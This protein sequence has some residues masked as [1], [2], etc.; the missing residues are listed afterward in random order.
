MHEKSFADGFLCEA[1]LLAVHLFE[2][3]LPMWSISSE[4]PSHEVHFKYLERFFR[5]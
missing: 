1:C 2:A 3:W 4:I 5:W